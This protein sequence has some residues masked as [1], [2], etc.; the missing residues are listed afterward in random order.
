MTLSAWLNE[1]SKTPDSGS[2]Q[3]PFEAKADPVV[4]W[5]GTQDPYKDS[6]A[7]TFLQLLAEIGPDASPALP[8]IIPFQE[9][10]NAD[11]R[12]AANKAR[13]RIETGR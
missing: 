9:S 12:K 5:I 2:S 6:C 7:D 10:T 8:A 4:D 1:Y 11:I 13:E 3:R